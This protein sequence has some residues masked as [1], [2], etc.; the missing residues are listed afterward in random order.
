MQM[1]NVNAEEKN[2][3]GELYQRLSLIDISVS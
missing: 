2:D 1:K 3:P